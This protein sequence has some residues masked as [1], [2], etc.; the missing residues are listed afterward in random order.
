MQVQLAQSALYDLFTSI[1]GSEASYKDLFGHGLD[2]SRFMLDPAGNIVSWNPGTLFLLH[3][4]HL[5][6]FHFVIFSMGLI[7]LAGVWKVIGYTRDEVLG[8]HVSMF[9]TI[10]DRVAGRPLADIAIAKSEGHLEVEGWMKRKDGE[11]FWSN[12]TF[13]SIQGDNGAV[14]GLSVVTR[15]FSDK[16]KHLD[17]LHATEE[18]YQM[19]V[20]SVTDYTIIMLDP[21]GIITTWNA[22]AQ[23][24]NGYHAEE[25]IGKHFSIFYD[26]EAL[27]ERKPEKELEQASSE[28]RFEEEGWRVKKDGTRFYANV[29]LSAIYNSHKDIVG[30]SKVTR[31]ITERMKTQ[32][33]ILRLSYVN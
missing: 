22:G 29:V 32:V 4:S 7:I 31:D 11:L 20:S 12:V 2:H 19:L 14:L 3:S 25:V 13:T 15:D 5:F 18:K 33:C 28:G 17:S 9:Y 8:Q 1:D 21:N 26:D 23:K 27:A 24:I 10:D 16:K 6:I 30:F